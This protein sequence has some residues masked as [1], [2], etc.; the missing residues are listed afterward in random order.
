[1]ASTNR[2][3]PVRVAERPPARALRADLLGRKKLARCHYLLVCAQRSRTRF[4]TTRL[5]SAVIA[6]PHSSRSVSRAGRKH[7]SERDPRAAVGVRRSAGVVREL[8]QIPLEDRFLPRRWF[9]ASIRLLQEERSPVARSNS[10]ATESNSLATET[11]L[12]TI[13][14]QLSAKP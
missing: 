12:R 4:S 9:T 1:M 13:P 11:D 7:S 6:L 3:L 8:D 5:R 14:S 10:L 2:S